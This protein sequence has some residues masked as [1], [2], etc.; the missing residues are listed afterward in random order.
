MIDDGKETKVF[1]FGMLIDV[2]QIWRY[3]FGRNPFRKF[4]LRL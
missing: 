1:W 4:Q 3:C 2:E